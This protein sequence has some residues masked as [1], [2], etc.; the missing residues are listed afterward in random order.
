MFFYQKKKYIYLFMDDKILLLAFN[1]LWIQVEKN[2]ENIYVPYPIYIYS[3]IYY[4]FK[5]VN[6]K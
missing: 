3:Y 4:Y 1:Y 6:K 2:I 5:S